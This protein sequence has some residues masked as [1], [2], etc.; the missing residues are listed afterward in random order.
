VF[1]CPVGTVQGTSQWCPGLLF[2]L[3]SF[4]KWK[5]RRLKINLKP[6]YGNNIKGGYFCLQVAPTCKFQVFHRKMCISYMISGLD[7]FPQDRWKWNTERCLVYLIL[8]IPMI[9]FL[10]KNACD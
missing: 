6:L 1:P 10:K 2:S 9:F 5:S 3:C 8:K 7:F 4:P